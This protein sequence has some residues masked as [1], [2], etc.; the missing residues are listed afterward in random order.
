MNFQTLLLAPICPHTAE[1]LYGKMNPGKSVMDAR[2]PEADVADQTLLEEVEYLEEVLHR[3][4]VNKG[5][6]KEE[7]NQNKP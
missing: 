7:R 1:F 5:E 2:W 3:M 6:L 4:R